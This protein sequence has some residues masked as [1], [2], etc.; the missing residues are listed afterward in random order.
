MK[1]I[2]PPRT[3][4]TRACSKRLN[5]KVR[6][7]ALILHFPDSE[8][9][10]LPSP[11]SAPINPPTARVMLR[12]VNPS[13]ISRGEGGGLVALVEHDLITGPRLANH[14]ANAVARDHPARTRQT[15][16]PLVVFIFIVRRQKEGRSRGEPCGTT[17]RASQPLGSTSCWIGIQSFSSDMF[18]ICKRRRT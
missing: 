17:S 9:T 3:P 10:I 7:S 12:I 11:V 8:P 15:S 1:S 16:S 13:R 18:T 6:W 2:H 5:S 14:H 4:L